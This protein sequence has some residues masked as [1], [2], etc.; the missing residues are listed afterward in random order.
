MYNKSIWQKILCL[1]ITPFRTDVN[2]G[3]AK[4]IRMKTKQSYLSHKS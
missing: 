1:L 4:S 3:T 2:L